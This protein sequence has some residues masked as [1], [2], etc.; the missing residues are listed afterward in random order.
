MIVRERPRIYTNFEIKMITFYVTMLFFVPLILVFTY[1]FDI[2][3]TINTRTFLIILSIING[4]LTIFGS[5]TFL[6]RKDQ[7]RRKVKANYKIE[8]Y[9]I[10]SIVVTNGH[11]E[12]VII[13]WLAMF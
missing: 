7:L 5:I 1:V 2:E 8:F 10:V 4:V 12:M 3:E 13:S 9:Y 11:Y 6:F